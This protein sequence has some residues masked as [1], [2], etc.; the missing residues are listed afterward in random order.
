MQKYQFISG[1]VLAI[2]L[3]GCDMILGGA[4]GEELIQP[5]QAKLTAGD[6][7]G[8]FNEY[9]ALGKSN[10]DS[11]HVAVGRAY[12]QMLAGDYP[13]ADA[14]LSAAEANAGEYV[15]EIKLRRAL[16]A[17]RANNVDQAGAH[18]AA[19]GLPTG[20]LMAAEVHLVNLESDEATRLFKELSS[21]GGEVGSTAQSYIS[22]LESGDVVQIALAEAY[23]LWSLGDREAAC[24]AA[25]ELLTSLETDDRDEK[26]LLWAGRAVTSGLPGDASSMLDSMEAPPPGQVWR[27]QAVKAMIAIAD[28]EPQRGVQ[29]FTALASMSPPADG[30][31]DALATAAALTDDREI[32]KQLAGSVES[33]AGARGLYEAGA[34]R[35]AMNQAPSGPFKT[36]LENR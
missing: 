5:A 31:S 8:A 13:S 20:K 7:P 23:A 14:T 27:V 22:L 32:A 15:G 10:G 16:L 1:L 9:D 2:A 26:L 34:V 6:L 25:S 28:G 18:G 17:L 24:N 3:S 19:S 30:L 21:A 36:F 12:S 35:A 4:D 33:A 29:I 11:V